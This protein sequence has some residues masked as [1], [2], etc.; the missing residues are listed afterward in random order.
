MHANEGTTCWGDVFV[1]MQCS[2]TE[3][4]WHGNRCPVYTRNSFQIHTGQCLTKTGSCTTG[5][6][7]MA[8]ENHLLGT[9]TLK[10]LPPLRAYMAKVTVEFEVV[11]PSTCSEGPTLRLSIF[12]SISVRVRPLACPSSHRVQQT[13][14]TCPCPCPC[15]CTCRWYFRPFRMSV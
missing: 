5:E 2:G 11:P 3:S 7:A 6:R 14:H 13:L 15:P 8:A 10:N 1:P 9:L 4:A 12:T